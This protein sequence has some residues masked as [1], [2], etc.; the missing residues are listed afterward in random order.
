MML[1]FAGSSQLRFVLSCAE[2]LR[3]ASRN[4]RGFYSQAPIYI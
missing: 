1:S 2:R 4:E 3:S